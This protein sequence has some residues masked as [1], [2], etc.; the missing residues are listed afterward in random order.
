[1]MRRLGHVN[2]TA[3]AAALVASAGGRLHRQPVGLR[4]QSSSAA[5]P[6]APAKGAPQRKPPAAAHDFKGSILRNR[7]WETHPAGEHV[8]VYV[9]SGVYAWI[10]MDRAGS[11]ANALG[12]AFVNCMQKAMDIVEKLMLEKKARVAIVASAKSSFCVG[13]DLEVLYPITDKQ[14]AAEA[15]RVGHAL[16]DRIEKEPFPVVAAINGFA[17]GGGFELSLACHHR[18]LASDGSVGLPECLL[19]VLPGAGG[20]VRL[21]RLVG[22]ATAVE[23]IMTSAPARAPKAKRAGAVNAVL[24]AEDRWSGEDRFFNQVRQW[25]GALV[26]KPLKPA[27]GKKLTLVERLLQS[28][29]AGRRIIAKKTIESLNAKTKGKYV[30]QYKALE[31]LLY[32]ATHSN[33]EGFARES[34]VFSELLVTPDAKNLMALY[35][36]EDGMKKS[37]LK[38]GIPKDK[39]PPVRTVGVIGAG[40]MGSGIVHHFANKAIPVAVNDLKPEAVEKG[41]AMVRGEFE[42]AAKRKKL[43]PAAV[44]AKMQLVKGGTS[45]GVLQGADVIVEAAVEVMDIKKKIIRELE[46]EGCLNGKNLFATNTSSLSL[47]EMQ[48]DAKYPANIVGMHFFNPVSKMPLVEVIKGKHTSKEA[49]AVIFDLALRTGKKPIIVN[50]APGFVV[51][52]ILGVYMAEA[53]RLAAVDKVDLSQIDKAILDFGMPMGPFRLLDEVGLDVACHVGPIL[54]AGIHPSRFGIGSEIQQMT[55]DGY[56]GKKNGKGFYRYDAKGKETGMNTEVTRHYFP[57]SSRNKPAG[58]IVDRCVLLMVNEAGYILQEKVAATP[59]DVDIGMIW[60]TGFP[61][62]RGGLLQHADHRGLPAVVDRLRQLQDALGDDRFAPCPLLQSM[63]K[64][65][66]R[67]FP[68]R[69]FVPYR[70]RAG[71][72]KV[73]FS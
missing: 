24:P 23:W 26:D 68:N 50:D 65:G 31:V 49:A 3:A 69:P 17:L 59:E 38:T 56:L 43:T 52:R 30:A 60:G 18:L 61:P 58:E 51:N 70:E 19:G 67:F 13:A 39:L 41:I 20:T 29:T 10:V 14:L 53:G 37:E 34:E 8:T 57:Q 21:Q 22:L 66:K 12:D 27:R 9:D 25:A 44:E 48:K 40:V 71:F 47:T 1:M 7:I 62:F 15:T 4:W 54:T 45:S 63:A 46:K 32:S 72:P 33:V 28:T 16:F 73:H 42:K 6:A 5:A 11:S 2:L 55:R 36:I 35:F 64:D